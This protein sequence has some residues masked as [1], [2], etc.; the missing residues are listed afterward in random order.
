MGMAGIR[1][2][3]IALFFACGMVSCAS[4]DEA[5]ATSP[6]QAEER[7]YEAYALAVETY[8]RAAYA[9]ASAEARDAHAQASATFGPDS[10]EAGAALSLHAAAEL[11]LGHF[12]EATAAFEASLATLR[13]QA[14]ADPG[15][16]AAAVGNLGEL[17]R[18][19]GQ[20]DRARPWIEESYR[21]SE[22]AYGRKHPKTAA[23]LAA[24]ALIRHQ[25]DELDQAEA[26]YV[27]A[28]ELLS[29]ADAP[30]LQRTVVQ[31]N[32]ADLLINTDRLEEAAQMLDAILATEQSELGPDHPSLAST[33]NTQ[34]TLAAT[35]GRNE[36]ALELY[37]R[38]L[39]IRR[40]ALPAGHPA[41]G[42][43]LSN[44]G[45]A[46][47]ELGD[48]AEARDSYAQALA[49]L[50]AAHGPGHPDVANLA[51]ALKALD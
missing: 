45:V 38:A 48:T 9:E 41:L 10:S 51:T 20:L 16:L 37:R 46:Y 23:A 25:M 31:S 33:L 42:V 49:I 3:L 4:T 40:V 26:A 13:R 18:Q 27:E 35:R 19:Q 21:V 39:A 22:D 1:A 2:A 44:M 12:P 8:E 32:L 30:L 29:A 47:Q 36:E 5:A 14:D 7:W 43:V 24:L 34:G 28:L 11:A 50:Q 6:T 15:D 17:Y